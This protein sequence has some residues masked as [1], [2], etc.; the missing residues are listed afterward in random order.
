M[1]EINSQRDS[2]T[3]QT[4]EIEPFSKFIKMAGCTLNAYIS[5]TWIEFR[6]INVQCLWVSYNCEK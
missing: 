3:F 6:S 4:H 5:S 1:E 2:N